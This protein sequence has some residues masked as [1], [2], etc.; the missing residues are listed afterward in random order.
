MKN[1]DL[2]LKRE[3][4][5]K[6]LN[7]ILFVLVFFIFCCGAGSFAQAQLAVLYGEKTHALQPARK[8]RGRQQAQRLADI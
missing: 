6:F 3:S 2:F 8:F 1:L 5:L 7:K 4:L